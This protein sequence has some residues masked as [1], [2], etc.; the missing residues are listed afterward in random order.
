MTESRA[1]RSKLV[2]K[3]NHNWASSGNLPDNCGSLNTAN[4]S[5]QICLDC[6][7]SGPCSTPLSSLWTYL[8]PL[9]QGSL[10]P[11]KNSK[12]KLNFKKWHFWTRAGCSNWI[13]SAGKWTKCSA[14]LSWLRKVYY[15]ELFGIHLCMYV[16]MYVCIYVCIGCIQPLSG[17]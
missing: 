12:N 4:C 13:L 5:S 17:C 1:G 2:P 11:E 10:A 16:H 9:L 7:V 3:W 14:E 6:L 8:N 15:K